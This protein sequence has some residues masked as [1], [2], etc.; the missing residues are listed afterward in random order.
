MISL[1]IALTAVWIILAEYHQLGDLRHFWF[2][3]HIIVIRCLPGQTK[4]YLD[5]T[6]GGEGSNK[7]REMKCNVES[8]GC[9]VE[10]SGV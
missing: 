8:E 2:R 4:I 6:G 1:I 7:E 9:R 5:I 10:C 3:I